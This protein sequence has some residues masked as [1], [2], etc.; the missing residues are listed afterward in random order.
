MT[1]EGEA[2]PTIG[3][4]HP[5]AMGSVIARELAALRPGSVLWAGEGRS[6]ESAERARLGGLTDVGTI[7]DLADRSEVVL[8]VCPPESAETV[9]QAVADTGFAGTYVDANAVSP[10]TARRVGE[11]F[12]DFVD[13]GIVGPPPTAPGLTRLYLSGPSAPSVAELFTGSAVEVRLVDQPG[14]ASAVKMCF[15]AWTKGTSALLLAIRAMA[16]AEGVTDSLLAEWETSMPDLVGRSNSTAG[17]VGPKAWR[18][19]GE[20]REIA[21]TF[22]SDGLPPDFHLAA[23]EVYRRLASLKGA[24]RPT[25]GEALN[26]LVGPDST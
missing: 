18:F 11:R 1:Q 9:A 17:A 22:E 5:G 3:V 13:G 19:E 16:E 26:L 2:G 15:A 24:D 4:L 20:M 6:A 21:A 23:A 7:S 12:D 25:I 14:S 8:S 10:E